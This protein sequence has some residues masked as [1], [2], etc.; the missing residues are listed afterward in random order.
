[1]YDVVIYYESKVYKNDKNQIIATEDQILPYWDGAGYDKF[2]GFG[3][4]LSVTPDKVS[5]VQITS[6][7][8]EFTSS[9]L[10]QFDSKGLEERVDNDNAII[11]LADDMKKAT[12]QHS[13]FIVK[14]TFASPHAGST[15][16]LPPYYPF[17]MIDAH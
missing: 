10:F 7:N 17:I 8:Y 16:L 15:L 13:N 11:I 2:N 1:M 14:T 3:Y 6:E 5:S 4:Q 9:P 12:K